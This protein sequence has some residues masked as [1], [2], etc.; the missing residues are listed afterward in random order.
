MTQAHAFLTPGRRFEKDDVVS[1]K[2]LPSTLARHLKALRIRS[3][4]KVS[5]LDGEGTISDAVCVND[6]PS[7][8]FRVDSVAR[9][10]PDA[11]EIHLFLSPP[12]RD[13]LSQTLT[14]ATEMGVSKVTF[15]ASDHN[16]Y[17]HKERES[18]V[19]RSKRVIE[20][21]VEQCRA[22]HVPALVEQWS[23]VTDAVNSYEGTILFADEDLSRQGFYGVTDASNLSKA[24]RVA[25]LVGPEGGWSDAE[26]KLIGA[27][28]RVSPLGLGPRILK[29]PT[30]CVAALYQI[31]S[32][33]RPRGET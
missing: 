10:A 1:E 33:M 2:D 23:S 5:F 19:E 25:L 20:A 3:G 4:E 17:S 32:L 21:A 8:S 12:R 16:D 30:A 14:Q 7:H 22:P 13:T 28:P 29:V 27:S 15:L 18:L 31:R 26:R 6:R 9:H 24:A 11:P